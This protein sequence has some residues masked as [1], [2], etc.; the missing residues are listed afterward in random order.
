MKPFVLQRAKVC[1]LTSF[2]CKTSTWVLLQQ[3]PTSNISMTCLILYRLLF[4]ILFSFIHLFSVT[5]YARRVTGGL[6]LFCLLH[7]FL[8]C[9]IFLALLRILHCFSSCF[10]SFCL[11]TSVMR[12]IHG[13]I[14]ILSVSYCVIHLGWNRS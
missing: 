2:L 4:F 5:A 10:V 1:F 13:W 14:N 7:N 12:D 11:V 6:V 9:Y 3:Q 8:S